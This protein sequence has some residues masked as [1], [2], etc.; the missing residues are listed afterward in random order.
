MS[1]S[2]PPVVKEIRAVLNYMIIEGIKYEKLEG[3]TYEMS[4]LRDDAHKL[5]FSKERIVPTKKSVYDY[6]LYDSGV[7]KKF[8]EGLEALKD[9]KYFI[10]LPGW[11]QIPTPVGNY[12]PD[13]AI[14]RK[15]GDIVYLI[16]E[17]KATKDQLQ[18]RGFESAK[19]KCGARHFE[20]IGVDYDVATSIMDANL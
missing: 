17:T 6:I 5:N 18:L 9:V 19:I 14:L 8:A 2:F 7:E 13:W 10:K 3:I 4:R 12:N 1:N 20:T 16:R 11:F 15:N